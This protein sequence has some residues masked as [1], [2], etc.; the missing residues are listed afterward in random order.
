MRPPAVDEAKLATILSKLSP[1][2]RVELLAGASM[3]ET[4][5]V[6]RAGVPAIRVTDG[7]NGARGSGSFAGGLSAACFPAAISLG[8]TW[9]PALVARVGA[10]IATE[11]RTKGAS[12]LLAPTVNI[13]RHPLNGRNFECYAEDPFLSARMAVGYITGVQGAGVGATVKHFVGNDSEYQRYTMSS[14]IDERTLREIYLVPFEAAV[15]EAGVWA[16]MTGYNRLNGTY[17]GEHAWLLRDLLKGEWGFDGL[18]MSDWFGTRSTIEAATNGLDLEMPGPAIFRGE[19]LKKAVRKGAVP[20]EAIDDSVLRLLRTIARTDGFSSPDLA[21]EQAID[22]PEHRALIRDAAVA[23]SVLLKNADD[24]LPLPPTLRRIA[25]IGPNADAAVVSGGGSARLF[26]HHTVDPLEGIRS[27][28]G[29]G[30]EVVHERGGSNHR[31]LPIVG[32]DLLTDGWTATFFA[33]TDLSGPPHSYD[34]PNSGEQMFMGGAPGGLRTGEFSARFSGVFVPAFDGPH[35]FSLISGGKS[36]LFVDGELVV[37][38]WDAYRLG[39]GYFGFGSDERIGS[40]Q[41][42]ARTPARIDIEYTTAEVRELAAVRFGMLQPQPA[43][44]IE[45]AVAAAA[46]ADAAILVVGGDHEWESEGIDRA[47]IALPREQ[48]ALVTA[49]ARANPRTIVVLQTGGPVAMPWLDDVEAVLQVWF[50]GQEI[51]D[52]IAAMLFGDA[53]PGG[54]LP[55]TFPARLED[56]P[57]VA[58]YPGVDGHV[59]YAEGVFVGYRHYDANGIAPLFPFGFGLGYTTFDMSGPT[60]AASEPG[61]DATIT[62]RVTVTNT[63]ARRGREV[64]QAYVRDPQASVPRPPRELK[65]FAGITLDPGQSGDVVI[66]LDRR[67]LA[68]WDVQRRGW[69][70]EAGDYVVEVGRS[71]RDIAGS[72]TFRLLET[73]VFMEP[74]A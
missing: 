27:R 19:A 48:D 6:P 18:V 71:S 5:A 17:C 46:N 9:D 51:G 64:V 50:G 12:I 49:V 70:A 60:L 30:V 72:A 61:R 34:Q 65:G 62:V 37:D 8:S 13:H 26:A 10:A 1:K 3:W 31:Y 41:L 28:A 69:V 36:R 33:S 39:S 14:D 2:Q 35:A 43:D 47:G 67:A 59:A 32:P 56:H 7:P 11:A 57:A 38:N 66:T 42:K 4:Y 20:Q 16:I 54:R 73:V 25:V 74:L 40:H 23:G 44:A 45:R 58:N 29:A 22:R 52:A 63:G 21:E 55:Q 68:W 53:E 24:A 15:C